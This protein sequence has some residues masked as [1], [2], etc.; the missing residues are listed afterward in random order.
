[1]NVLITFSDGRLMDVFY[2]TSHGRLLQDVFATSQKK[3]IATSISDQYKTF[4]RPK[5]RRFMDLFKTS[6]G[7]LVRIKIRSNSFI[8]TWVKMMRG[9]T[10]EGA[11]IIHVQPQNVLIILPEILPVNVEKN[12]TLINLCNFYIPCKIYTFLSLLDATFCVWSWPQLNWCNMCMLGFCK[13]VSK[14]IIN[15]CY[16]NFLYL[17][18]PP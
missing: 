1:M 2:R 6:Y 9:N 8:R 14:R 11:W 18:I 17:N 16:C 12:L 5:I 10:D 4:L 3:V 13:Q 15:Y 7:R